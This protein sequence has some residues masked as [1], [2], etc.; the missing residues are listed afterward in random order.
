MSAPSLEK[1]NEQFLKQDLRTVTQ[2][3]QEEREGKFSFFLPSPEKLDVSLLIGCLEKYLPFLTRVVQSPYVILKSEYEQVRTERAGSMSPQAIRMTV[4]DSSLWKKKGKGMR[5]EY[6][7]TVTNEDEY[8]TYEN[9][10]VYSLIDKAIHFLDLPAEYAREGVKNLYESYFQ[11]AVFNKLDL[12]RIFDTDLFRNSCPESFA[13]YEKLFRL[14]WKLTQ[15]RGSHFY[16]MLS[17]APRFTGVPEATNLF[18]HNPDYNGCFRLWRSLDEFYAGLSL[19][20]QAQQRSVYAAFVFLAMVSCY[21]RLGFAVERDASV[22]EIDNDFS[23]REFCLKNEDF[24]V[25]LSADTDKITVLVQCAKTHSQQT[26]LIHLRTD[27]SEE[28]PAADGFTVSLHRTEYR[29][30]AACVVPG[31]KN[32]LKDLESIVRCTVLTFAADKDIYGRV[33]LV[34]GSNLVEDRERFFRCPDCGAVYTFLGK[35]KVWLN[36]FSV[37][38]GSEKK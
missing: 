37:L 11:S 18:V 7:Y 36:K 8:A 9:R 6:V 34:C 28:E 24:N 23:V 27:V 38:S 32:S 17:R 13:D 10:V 16:K 33:C 21:V 5:P 31:N 25:I 35:D 19:L 20:T 30:N 29:D 12:V 4:K 14:R 2:I 3:L 22:G 1:F 15:L 26:S